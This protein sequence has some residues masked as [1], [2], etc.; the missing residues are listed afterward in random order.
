MRKINL[1]VLHCSATR[2]TQDYTSEQLE[3]D[4]KARGFVRAGYNYYVRRSGQIVPMRP[5][6]QIPAHVKGYN[7]NSI[8]ICYEGGL[9]A[10][11]NPEDTRTDEQKESLK[12]L[13]KLL[14][15]RYPMS[16]ICG[17]RDLGAHKACPCFNAEE[18]YAEL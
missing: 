8:G 17:H 1:I 18:E 16:R 7:R 15:I 10:A 2:E 11:G 5:L 9:D 12:I 4:H 6:E 14:K 3:R 13:L